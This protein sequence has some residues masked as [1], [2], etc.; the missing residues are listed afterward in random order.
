M[1]PRI[2]FSH[3]LRQ[4][5]ESAARVKQDCLSRRFQQNAGCR[6]SIYAVSVPADRYAPPGTKDRHLIFFHCSHLPHLFLG[7][8][9][10]NITIFFL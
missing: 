6:P 1:D 10:Y 2:F 8:Y 7:I 4:I 3:T 5:H 9:I